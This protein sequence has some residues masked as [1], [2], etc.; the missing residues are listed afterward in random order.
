MTTHVKNN[1]LNSIEN[2]SV[3]VMAVTFVLL[4]AIACG[5]LIYGTALFA[6]N[7]VSD[8]FY[9]STGRVVNLAPL[10]NAIAFI[11]TVGFLAVVCRKR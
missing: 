11:S 2:F 3:Y 7:S 8:S 5:F 10:A 4:V 1:S 9:A 6:L